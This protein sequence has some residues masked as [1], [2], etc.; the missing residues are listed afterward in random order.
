MGPHQP[1]A[2][3]QHSDGRAWRHRPHHPPHHFTSVP[4]AIDIGPRACVAC[5]VL[6]LV[7][8]PSL[9]PGPERFA[10]IPPVPR[11]ATWHCTGIVPKSRRDGRVTTA[12]DS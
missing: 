5:I 6:F 2:T 8:G 10:K 12:R 9:P 7:G 11:N 3:P 1:L 4:S